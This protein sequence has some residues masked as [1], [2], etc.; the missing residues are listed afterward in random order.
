MIQYS[1][2]GNRI[3]LKLILMFKEH[4]V[5]IPKRQHLFDIYIIYSYFISGL[6]KQNVFEK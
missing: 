3:N 1:L 5:R 2:G 4:N 6:P